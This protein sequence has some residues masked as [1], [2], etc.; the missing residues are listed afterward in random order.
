MSCRSLKWLLVLLFL[1]VAS[2]AQSLAGA[3]NL[4]AALSAYVGYG[5]FASAGDLN[6]RFGSGF[7]IDGGLSWTPANSGWELGA[8]VQY[9]FGN[10][11]KE[12]VLAGLRTRDGFIVGNQ[13][14][15]A[16][17]QLRQRQLFVGPTLGYTLRISRNQ[18]AGLHLKFSPG[19]FFHRIRIQDDPIQGVAPLAD[20]LRPSYDRLTGGFAVHQFLGYQQLAEN[21]RLNFYVGGEILAGFTKGLRAFD[22]P[23][24]GPPSSNG[25]TD[26]LFGLKV[27]LIIPF[28]FGEGREIFY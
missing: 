5:P 1:P 17:V 18:R 12:D 25:R 28:Y 20:A 6:E 19:Y 4:D 8:R 22:I 10:E 2:A 3:K 23:T 21:R 13:R 9:G 11:V 14:E 26:M 24:G 15:P 16:D 27:G 7:A